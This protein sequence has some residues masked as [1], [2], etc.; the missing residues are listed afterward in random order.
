MHL[1]VDSISTPFAFVFFDDDGYS[2]VYRANMR[3]REFDVFLEE[4]ES[5]AKKENMA[6]QDVTSI[7][8]VSG[9]AQF[10]SIR[11]V[12]LTLS[13]L[14][15]SYDIPLF[16]LDFFELAELGAASYPMLVNTNRAQVILKP[17]PDTPA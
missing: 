12:S 9:P 11:I 6:L 3:G 1:L 15:K 4:L 10:T 8:A 5:F 2:S 16:S 14:A 7:T 13:T 17:H